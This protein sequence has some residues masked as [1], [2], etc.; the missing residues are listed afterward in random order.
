MGAVDM[1]ADMPMS[2]QAMWDHVADLSDLGDRL[3][4]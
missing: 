2:P 1:T 3:V 4:I